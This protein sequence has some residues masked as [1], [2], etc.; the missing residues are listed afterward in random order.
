MN[1]REGCINA[2][3][4]CLIKVAVASLIIYHCI[5]AGVGKATDCGKV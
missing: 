5:E 4:W 1:S 3:L 2:G